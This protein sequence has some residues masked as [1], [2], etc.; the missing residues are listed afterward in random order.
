MG[1]QSGDTLPIA[2]A[3]RMKKAIRENDTVIRIGGDEFV[4]ILSGFKSKEELIVLLNRILEML[5]TPFMFEGQR[6]SLSASCGATIFPEDD[7]SIS[8]LITHADAAMYV[9]KAKGKN[10]WVIHANQDNG[11][12]TAGL[13]SLRNTLK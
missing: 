10:T 12:K 1:H 11:N 7:S 5:A 8:D 2:A 3:G 13:V 4:L 6:V 9:A